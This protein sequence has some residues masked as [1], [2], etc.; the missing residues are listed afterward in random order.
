LMEQRQRSDPEAD[1]RL[2]RISVGVE[3][4]EVD[5]SQIYRGCLDSEPAGLEEGSSKGICRSEGTSRGVLNASTWDPE[6]SP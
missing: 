6:V 5:V 4:L 3:D 2:I 1:P